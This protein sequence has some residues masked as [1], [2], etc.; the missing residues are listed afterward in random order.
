MKGLLIYDWLR[1]RRLLLFYLLFGLGLNS[2]GI[3]LLYSMGFL[4]PALMTTPAFLLGL[5]P[6]SAMMQD[7]GF[8]I[9]QTFATLPVSRRA[10][11]DEKYLFTLLMDGLAA[12]IYLIVVIPGCI[13]E[14]S[15]LLILISGI[16]LIS[17]R[18]IDYRIP[19]AFILGFFALSLCFRLNPFYELMTGGALFACV[20]MATDP[21]T[22][23][24]RPWL[25]WGLGILAGALTILFRRILPFAEGVSAALLL[26]NLLMLVSLG[27]MLVGYALAAVLA[28][29]LLYLYRVYLYALGDGR[30]GIFRT[31]RFCRSITK[32]RRLPL[33]FLDLSF[34]WIHVMINLAINIVSGLSTSISTLGEAFGAPQISRWMGLHPTLTGLLFGLLGIAAAL[35]L[36]YWMLGRIAVTFA[37]VYEK[38]THRPEADEDHPLSYGVTEE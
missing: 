22:S 19:L 13:G 17:R 16:Y 8:R 18:I 27:A 11:V 36:Y 14:T 4:I 30:G 12:V 26:V 7:R 2:L 24:A 35:P 38:L 32:G 28:V 1:H 5:E 29:V 25:K 23:P 15:K 31:A 10:V 33:F 37:L 20:F 21:V 34:L 6:A 9:R 3:I